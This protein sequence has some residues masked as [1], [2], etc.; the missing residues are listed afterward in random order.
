MERSPRP[1]PAPAP[2]ASGKLR[3]PGFPPTSSSFPA[4]GGCRLLCPHHVAPECWCPPG[5]SPQLSTLPCTL[6]LAVTCA[7]GLGCYRR[8]NL[9]WVSTHLAARLPTAHPLLGCTNAAQLVAT[10]CFPFLPPPPCRETGL[11]VSPV[12]WGAPL[13]PAAWAGSWAFS[14]LSVSLT[15]A[16]S[17]GHVPPRPP[18]LWLL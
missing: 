7:C 15:P 11:P 10:A 13:F 14:R 17:P 1:R 3:P 16:P 2:G 18:W 8:P 4:S 12:T 6:A 5:V 9:A